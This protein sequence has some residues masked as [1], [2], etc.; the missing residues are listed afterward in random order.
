[1]NIISKIKRTSS[2]IKFRLRELNLKLVRLFL[3]NRVLTQF[4]FF[5]GRFL[6]YILYILTN[7]KKFNFK[8]CFITN[9]SVNARFLT[10]YMGLKLKSKFPLFFVINPLKKEFR[11]L[12]KKKKEKKSNLFFNYFSTKINLNKIN[13]NYKESYISVL[14]YLY[15]KYLE[16]SIFYYKKYQMLITFDIFYYFFMLKKRYKYKSL[17]I[18]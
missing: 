17:L 8:F 12:S 14:K 4:G 10:R 1:M 3:F 18:Y 16:I 13:I 5:Y 11:K 6:K 15:S 2:R 7:M 9:N